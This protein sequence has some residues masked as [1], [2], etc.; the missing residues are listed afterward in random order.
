MATSPEHAATAEVA[1]EHGGGGLPQFEFQYWGGQIVWL[2]LI[3]GVLYVLLGRVFVPRLRKVI[4]A[5]ADSIAQAVASARSVQAQA[6]AEA[7]AAEQGLIEA[8]AAAQ[9][10]AADAKAKAQTEAATRR[11]AEDA[12]LDRKTADAEAR[13]RATR[14][15]AMASVGEVAAEAVQ[16][17]VEKL[18]GKGLSAGEAAA[19]VSA[20]NAPEGAA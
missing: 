7:K 6:D 18:T 8:R 2:L 5:R 19:A 16:G 14:Q 15:A 11:A 17:I 20:L 4:D 1:G 13:I 3:F 10:T 9:R 12:E